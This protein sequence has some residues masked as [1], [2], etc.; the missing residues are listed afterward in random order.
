[1][2]TFWK[3]W[4]INS[5]HFLW[6]PEWEEIKVNKLLVFDDNKLVTPY[7]DSEK[8]SVPPKFVTAFIF[9][10]NWDN[11]SVLTLNKKLKVNWK[12][13]FLGRH[14]GCRPLDPTLDIWSKFVKKEKEKRKHFTSLQFENH[15][16]CISGNVTRVSKG[17]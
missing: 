7:L 16:C 3:K 17:Y 13:Q 14:F 5:W 15:K 1:M 8:F 12:F 9:T 2:K 11:K 6:F 10:Y 4:K